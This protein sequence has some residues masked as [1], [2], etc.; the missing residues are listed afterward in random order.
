MGMG[1]R[2]GIGPEPRVNMSLLAFL[3]LKEYLQ[4]AL[5]LHRWGYRDLTECHVQSLHCVYVS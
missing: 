3:G 1:M 4:H 5:F 2:M